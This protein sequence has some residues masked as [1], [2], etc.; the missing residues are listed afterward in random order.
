MKIK[1]VVSQVFIGMTLVKMGLADFFENQNVYCC[2][3]ERLE[4]V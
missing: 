2:I 4:A 1:V 3:E